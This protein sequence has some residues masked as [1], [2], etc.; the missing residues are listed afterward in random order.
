MMSAAADRGARSL[1]I[2]SEPL[3]SDVST[4]LEA[5]EYSILGAW[6][7]GESLHLDA[8]ELAA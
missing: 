1:I 4:W 3:T 7:D 6:F 5:P 8:R 2:A